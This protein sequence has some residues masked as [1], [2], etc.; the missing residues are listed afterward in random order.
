[1]ST[2][3]SVQP[4]TAVCPLGNRFAS[5][6][7]LWMTSCPMALSCAFTAAMFVS[8]TVSPARSISRRTSFE[9]GKGA[10]GPTPIKSTVPPGS[11]PPPMAA[12]GLRPPPARS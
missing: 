1:M 6:L 2:V 3:R 4:I 11:R 8:R 12:V 7:K 9:L 5:L 10:F